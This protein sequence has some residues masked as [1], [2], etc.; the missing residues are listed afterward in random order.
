[1][2]IRYSF[3]LVVYPGVGQPEGLLFLRRVMTGG[4]AKPAL[5]FA[6]SVIAGHPG[7]SLL[8]AG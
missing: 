8:A 2:S 4:A 6:A 5:R 7:G 3:G 1:M